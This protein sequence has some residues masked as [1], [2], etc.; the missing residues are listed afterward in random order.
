MLPI[1]S[2]L[3]SLF[4]DNAFPNDV[5]Q[6]DSGG[7]ATTQLSLSVVPFCTQLDPDHS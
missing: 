6:E 3:P 1:A 4:I 5:G 2:M 7:E